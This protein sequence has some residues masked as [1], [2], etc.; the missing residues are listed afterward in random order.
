M[1]QNLLLLLIVLGIIIIF[2]G[3][4]YDVLFA[5]IPY[6]D[7]TP[8]MLASYN[9]HSQIASIIR[10]IGVGICTIS[11]MAIITRWLMKKDHK[12]GA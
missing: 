9:F 5:G 8:A 4:V 1:K 6:Q 7:P 3:F 10:W 11:G 12:Q 2:G